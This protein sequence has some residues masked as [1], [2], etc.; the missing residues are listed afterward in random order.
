MGCE[1]CPIVRIDCTLTTALSY[2]NRARS[3]G[4]EKCLAQDSR[5]RKTLRISMFVPLERAA[6][7]SGPVP[8]AFVGNRGLRQNGVAGVSLRLSGNTGDRHFASLAKG[9][10]KFSRRPRTMS[11]ERLDHVLFSRS[12][13][14]KI[15]PLSITPCYPPLVWRLFP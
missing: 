11:Y 3:P 14:R 1:P 10:K 7:P 12:H 8:T 15:Y 5:Q 4:C 2:S 13:S 9:W 6:T